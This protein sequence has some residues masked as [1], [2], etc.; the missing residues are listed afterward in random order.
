MKKYQPEQIVEKLRQADVELGK[1]L[2][3]KEVC[4]TIETSEQT[5]GAV[6][7]IDDGMS[8][9]ARIG[10][11]PVHPSRN[12]LL[13]QSLRTRARPLPKLDVD[14]SHPIA[15]CVTPVTAWC[16]HAKNINF[17]ITV[18]PPP[19]DASRWLRR[20]HRDLLVASHPA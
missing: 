11:S 17:S 15:C 6:R 4:R 7:V 12:R 13:L 14:G 16:L 1:G 10:A 18:T 5:G 9:L 8:A 2:S 3:V 19:L 20:S